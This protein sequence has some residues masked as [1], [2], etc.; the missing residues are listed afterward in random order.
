MLF[1]MARITEHFKVI[2]LIMRAITVLMMHHE[3]ALRS[4]AVTFIKGHQFPIVSFQPFRFGNPISIA[5][6]TYFLSL[7]DMS[8]IQRASY[9]WFREKFETYN[10]RANGASSAPIRIQFAKHLFTNTP[11][12]ISAFPLSR[13]STSAESPASN[14]YLR[15]AGCKDNITPFA[16]DYNRTI[17]FNISMSH[18]CSVSRI[19]Q[20]REIIWQSTQQ[21]R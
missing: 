17:P 3:S 20:R 19:G 16:I 7:K 18:P 9:R 21:V 4:A 1:C 14:L 13:T 12:I 6:S 10:T 11:L 2:S 15:W 8:A 5:R